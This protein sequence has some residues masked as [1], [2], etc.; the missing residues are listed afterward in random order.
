M[1]NQKIKRI[2]GPEGPG[3][4]RERHK[5]LA[6]RARA[7]T[8]APEAWRW[9]PLGPGDVSSEVPKTSQTLYVGWSAFLTLP[10]AMS[11]EFFV[12]VICRVG[13]SRV[14]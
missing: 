6:Q 2:F 14:P 4:E 8:D 10:Y 12:S 11:F 13:A 9:E 5:L 1:S 3:P 7:R